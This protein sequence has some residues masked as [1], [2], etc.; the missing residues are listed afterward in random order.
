MHADVTLSESQAPSG[1]CLSINVWGQRRHDFNAD[2]AGYRLSII[3]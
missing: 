2:L 3:I 1:A